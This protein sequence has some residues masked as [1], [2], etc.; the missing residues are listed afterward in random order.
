MARRT[1][2]IAVQLM[3]Q[4]SST[5]C[6]KKCSVKG[7]NLEGTIL[8]PC[9]AKHCLLGIKHLHT[10]LTVQVDKLFCNS[11]IHSTT[12]HEA[13]KPALYAWLEEL[14]PGDI[15]QGREEF[16]DV[17][18]TN[19]HSSIAYI[20]VPRRAAEHLVTIEG[21]LHDMFQ[22]LNDNEPLLV[23]HDRDD[24]HAASIQVRASKQL[25]ME[26]PC[27]PWLQMTAA[28][29]PQ[30]CCTWVML[31]SCSG[32]AQEMAADS[33]N[34][35]EFCQTMQLGTGSRRHKHLTGRPGLPTDCVAPTLQAPDLHMELCEFIVHFNTPR[36][37]DRR[38]VNG[39]FHL[40]A[41][42]SHRG[43][44]LLAAVTTASRRL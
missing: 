24:S 5:A 20:E 14:L 27:Q 37:P 2:S 44:R 21:W 38:A 1:I 18:R 12:T 31:A 3:P 8:R 34:Q 7:T 25:L 16:A 39:I 41:E 19:V 43:D 36:R 10:V 4:V 33:Q 32:V 13:A 22:A 35:L 30:G 6:C 23:R 29:G 15:L 9:R 28:N 26:E 40:S 17:N 11:K 42:G